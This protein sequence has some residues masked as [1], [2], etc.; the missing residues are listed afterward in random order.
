MIPTDAGD[1]PGYPVAGDGTGVVYLQ[2]TDIDHVR[3]WICDAT[4]PLTT[5][6]RDRYLGRL[7][8]EDG[9]G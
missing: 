7:S 4:G 2:T 9:C 1:G 6:E 3:D 8:A 5:A